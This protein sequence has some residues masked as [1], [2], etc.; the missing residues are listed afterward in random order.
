MWMP[1]AACASVNVHGWLSKTMLTPGSVEVPP[2]VQ[3]GAPPVPVDVVVVPPVPVDVVVVVPPV[4]VDVVV[5]VPVPVAVDVDVAP[6]M[7]AVLPEDHWTLL[8]HASRARGS[9][10]RSMRSVSTT[11]SV[12]PSDHEARSGSRRRVEPCGELE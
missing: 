12:L 8:P 5:V 6:P 10:R 3:A 9:A 4:P 7:P 2:I 11:S 1:A